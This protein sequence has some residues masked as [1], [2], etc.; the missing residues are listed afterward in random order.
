MRQDGTLPSYEQLFGSLDFRE[1]DEARSVYSPAAYLADLLQLLDDSFD[2]VPLTGEDRRPDLRTVP[3]DVENT[4]TEVPYLDI[5]NQVLARLIGKDALEELAELRFPFT[6]PFSLAHEQVKRYLFHARVSPVELYTQ[7]AQRIDA[8]VVAREYLG[9]TTGDVELLTTTTA[10]DQLKA[11]YGLAAEAS[12]TE[13]ESVD[14]F[15]LTTGLTRAQ[16]HELLYQNLGPAESAAG[17]FVHQGGPCVTL[18]AAE[19]RLTPDDGSASVPAEWFERVHRFL[20]LVRRTGLS[21]ADTDLV[22]RSCCGN[23]LDA[24]ALRTI[25]VV[26]DLH[27]GQNLPVDVVC[28]LVSP[29]STSGAGADGPPQDLFN[30]VF[31]APF[32]ATER[33]V[34]S[35]SADLPPSYADLRRLAATGDLL[36][37]QNREYR[38]RVA[39]AVGLTDAGIA[40]VVSRMRARFSGTTAQSSLFDRGASELD[41]LSLLH[42]VGR[43]AGALD[44][45][46]G[47]LF[48]LLDVLEADSS[49]R[50][51]RTF[52]E[53]LNGTPA[54]VDL[55]R[56]LETPDAGPALR[57]MQILFGVVRW[58]R[59]AG[60]GSD[61]LVGIVGGAAEQVAADGDVLGAVLAEL[62]RQFET[63][64]LAPGTFVSDRFGERASRVVRDALAATGSV[65]SRRDPRLLVPE[66]ARDA[67][68]A[69]SEAYHAMAN[70]VVITEDDFCGLGLGARLGAKI[71]ANLVF[72]GHVQPSGALVEASLP[73]TAAG[74][75]ISTD[76]ERLRERLFELIS[77]FCAVPGA[78]FYPSDLADFGDLTAAQQAEL[79]DNLVYN[80]YLDPGGVVLQPDFF[81]ADNAAA[82]ALNADLGDA[83]PAVW[84]LLRDRIDRFRGDPLTLD[85]TI[86]ADLPLVE[87]QRADLLESLRFNGYID[88]ENRYVDKPALARL[89]LDDL[90][91]AVQFYPYRRAVLDAM[92]AQLEAARNELLTLTAEQFG[93][94]AD[95]VVARRVVGRLDGTYLVDGVLPDEMRLFFADPGSQLDADDLD[96]SFSA[97]DRVTITSQIA[98]ILAEEQPYRLDFR[99]LEDLGFDVDESTRLAGVLVDAGHLNADLSVPE[100]RLTFFGNVNNALGFTL[101]GLVDYSKDIFFLLHAIAR[102]TSAG[103]KEITTVLADLAGRQLAVLFGV[104]QDA[105]GLPAATVEAICRGVAA[106]TGRAL[107]I[108][109]APALAGGGRSAA[110]PEVR[111]TYRRIRRFAWLAGKLGLDAVQVVAAFQDQDLVAKFA[112][113]LSLPPGVDRIDALLDSADGNVYLF[114]G[115]GYWVYSPAT[116]ALVTPQARP[117]NELSPRLS[118]LVAVDA[119]F[120]D[121]GGT[122]WIVGRTSTAPGGAG[123]EVFVRERGTHHWTRREQPWGRI[124]NNFDDPARIDS[125]FVDDTGR[126]YLFCGDQYVRYSG[127][128]YSQVDEG[129]PRLIGDWRE[130]EGDGAALPVGFRTVDASFQDRDGVTH[131]FGGGRHLTVGTGAADQPVAGAWGKV[132]NAFAGAGRVD[133]AYAEPARAVL[134]AGDQV[135]RYSDCIENDDVYVDE[136]DPCGIGSYL[137]GVPAGF[138]GGLDAAFTDPAGVLHLFKNGRTVALREG[139]AGPVEPTAERWGALRPVLSGGTVDSAVVGLDGKTYLFSGDR[140][141][142]YSGTDYSVA[143]VGYPRAIAADWG[144]LLRVDASFVLDQATYLFGTAGKLFDLPPAHEV[145]LDASRMSRS[146]RLKFLEHGIA[147]AED[148]PV[149]GASPQ[150]HVTADNQMAFTLRREADRIEVHSDAGNPARW[151]VRYSSRDY[152]IPDA[153][154]PK[155]LADNWWNLPAGLLEGTVDAVFT[156]RDNRTYLFSGDSYVVFDNKRRWWSES[157]SLRQLWGSLP[158]DRVDAAFV[159]KDGRTYVFSGDRYVR[160]AGADY[161]RVDDRYPAPV[162]SYWGTVTNN[163]ART[164]RVDAALVL[165]QNTYL[166]SGNQ[167]VRYTGTEYATVDD[168]YP[169]NLDSLKSEPRLANLHV[170]LSGGLDAAFADRHTVYLFTGGRWHA[171]SDVDY[172]SYP[173]LG[174]GPGGCAFVEDGSVLVEEPG[175][176]LRYSALEGAEV[177]RTPVRPRTLRAVPEGFRRG[178]DAVLSGVDGNT[179]L[180]KQDSCFNVEANGAYPLAE[181]WGRPRNNLYHDGTVDAGFV[182]RD[183][184]TYVFSGDQFIVYGAGSG[185]DGEI[186]GEP[187]PVAEH[188]GGLSSVALAYMRDGRTYLF[189][190]PDATG[191]TRYVVYSGDDY[192]EP[193]PGGSSSADP[194]FWDIPQEYRPDG[195]VAPDAVVFEGG[196]MLVVT[197]D[198]VVRRHEPTGTWSPPQPLSRFWPG[199]DRERT[200]PLTAGFRG[201]D[202]A[203]YLFFADQFTRCDGQTCSPRRPVRDAWGR[204]RNNFVAAGGRGRVDAA[205][206]DRGRTTFLFSGDQYVRYSR[207]DYRYADAGYP[208]PIAGNLRTEEAFASLP[209]S[210]EDVVAARVEAAGAGGAVIDAVIGNRRTVYLFV[211]GDC[212][213]VSRAPAAT[214]DLGIL[215]QVRNTIAQRGRVDA[216]LVTGGHTYLFSGDQYVRYTGGYEFVDE[217]YPRSIDTGLPADLGVGAL[218][219]EFGDGVDVAFRG[220]DGHTYLFAGPQYLQLDGPATAGPQPIGDAW[221]RI[222][223]EFTA[224]A[225]VDAAFVAPTGE[226]YAFRRGQYVRYRPGEFDRVEE[227]FPR[228]VKDDW[229]ELPAD[230]EDGIDG[231]FVFEGR[232][233]LCRDG[234][235]VR[236]SG[237]DYHRVD[238]RFPQMVAQRWSDGP[239]YQL[240]DVYTIARVAALVRAHDGLAAFLSA[241]PATVG[242]PYLRL[243][244]LFGW[245]AEEVRWARRHVGLLTGA[246][247]PDE[248]VEL[249]FLLRLADVFAIA[250]R[251]G[252]GP[253]TVYTR[254]WL[255]MYGDSASPPA[256]ALRDLLARKVG[257]ADWAVL[258]RQIHDEVNLLERDALLSVVIARTGLQSSRDLFDRLLIDVDMGSRATT[259]PIREAVAATQLYL[260][261]YF[262]NLEEL[263]AAPERAEEVRNR[264][265]TWWQWMR[266]YRTWEANRKVFLYPENYLRPELR[267]SKTPAFHTLESDLLQ[268]EI[269]PE[270]V[271]RA[272]KKYLD[273]Y[274]EVS[275]LAIGG[276]YVYIGDDDS[277]R[278]LVLFGR[279]RTQPR[280]YYY[281]RARFRSGDKLSASWEPWRKV[282]VQIDA[283]EVN[284]VHAFDRVFVFWTTVE[285]VPPAGVTSTTLVARRDGDTNEVSA[286]ATT[287]RVKIYY[288][289]QNLNGEWVPAQTLPMDTRQDGTIFGVT[290]SVTASGD[291]GDAESIVV[292]CSY[293]V[294][295]GTGD[296]AHVTRVTQASALTPELYAVG[297][298]AG[299][300]PELAGP[301]AKRVPTAAAAVV[302]TGSIFDIFEG[303]DEISAV[304]AA[305]VANTP[306]IV[307]FNSPANASY[308]P[309]F[310]VDHKGGS[311]LCYPTAVAPGDEPAPVPLAGNDAGLPAWPRIDAA[312]ETA[313]GTRYF[314]DNSGRRYVTATG[315][316]LGP[317][318][319]IADSWG[320]TPNNITRTG[321][322]DAILG[323]GRYTYVF[324]GDQYFRYSGTLFGPV[325]AGYPK[326]LA[327]N[328][329]RLPKWPRVDLAFTDLAGTEWFYS[330]AQGLLVRGGALD[331]PLRPSDLWDRQSTAADKPPRID[332]DKID[333]VLI[334]ADRDHTYVFSGSQYRRFSGRQYREVDAGYPTDIEGNGEGIPALPRIDAAFRS[335]RVT[336][337]FTNASHAYVEIRGTTADADYETVTRMTSQIGR[338]PGWTA[339]DAAYVDGGYLYVTSGPQ[340]ARYTLA[341]GAPIPDTVDEGYPKQM[342]RALDAVFRRGTRRY[343]FS[344]GLYSQLQPG[345][346][347]D[348]VTEF[349]PIERNWADLPADFPGQFTGVLDSDADGYLYLFFTYREGSR[350]VSR[351]VR[352]P[353]G[354]TVSRPYELATLPLEIV[355]LTTSTAAQLNQRLLAGGVPALLDL[356]TQEIDESPA[357]TVDRSDRNTIQLRGDRVTAARLPASSHLDFQSANGIYYW[358]IFFHAPALIA[359]ALNDAQRFEDARTWYEYVFNPTKPDGYW[360]F[361]PFLAADVAALAENSAREIAELADEVQ[362]AG[363]A[364]ATAGLSDTLAPI[365]AGLATLAPAF[366]QNRRLTPD[367]EAILDMF[368][369]STLPTVLVGVADTIAARLTPRVREPRRTALRRALAAARELQERTAVVAGLRRQYDYLG[370]RESLLEAYRNDPFDPHA[371]ADLRPVAHRRAVVMAYIDNLLDWGD[372]LFRQYT[373]ESV[374][375]ARMLYILAWDL[376]GKRPAGIGRRALP[377][378]RTFQQLEDQPDELDPLPELTAGGALL[379][380]SGAVYAGLANGYFHVPDN[381]AFREYW[382]RVEDRLYKIRQSLNIMGIS[383]PLPLFEPEQDVMALV[384]ATAAGAPSL[385]AA[386]AAAALVPHFRFDTT[387]AAARDLVDRLCQFGN[388]LLG[389]LDRR[390]SE[391]LSLLQSRQ[392]GVILAM[393]RAITEAQ[394]EIAA[395][396][397]RELEAGRDAVT[398]RVQYY[399]RLST[400]GLSPLEQAQVD[401]MITAATLHMASGTMKIGSAIA[402][403]APQTKLG[404][405][406]I[407]VEWGGQELG[408]VLDKGS[409]I[410]QTL[411]EGFSILGELLGVRAEQARSQA[412]W[413]F[414]LS[415]ARGDLAQLEQRFA[416]AEQALAVAQRE[417]DVLRQQ[418]ANQQEVAAFLTGKFTGAGLYQWMAGRL[419][420]LYFQAYQLAYDLARQAELAFQFERGRGG[421]EAT[422]I[423][424]QYW[425]SLRGGLLA[426]ESLSLDLEL[427]GKACRDASGRGL[428]ITKRISLLELDPVALYRLTSTGVCEFS[429]TEATFDH[430]FPGH[431]RRQ[432]RTVAVSFDGGDG[433]PVR[434]N[435]TLT[436]LGHK[437]V[438]EA[439]PKAVKHLLDPTQPPP[440]TVRSDWRPSQQIVLS[441]GDQEDTGLFELR[442][443]DPRYLPF[444]GTGAISTWRLALTGLRPPGLRDVTLII[445][446]T[447]QPGDEV[448]A[449]AVKGMLKPYQAARFVDVAREFPEQWQDFLDADQPELTLPLTLN[450][451]PGMTGHQITGI[452]SRYENSNGGSVRFVLGGPPALTLTEGALLPTPG[453]TIGNGSNWVLTLDGDRTG[454]T[455]VGL[456]LTYQ[457]SDQ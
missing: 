235:Y 228:L 429:L 286:P 422:Y 197:G 165:D 250:D 243:T 322:V 27:R 381:S 325:D 428:E 236:Y 314:F 51:Q 52:G 410:P 402:Y 272:Y 278:D 330:A 450:M 449:N 432:I 180:F 92:Q 57:L 427:L 80:G 347:L 377:A 131:L 280:R 380:G 42:R 426:G 320:R 90:G 387:F 355:R 137:P 297:L 174:P 275:R 113:P 398:A 119:A 178:L 442:L 264:L 216:A 455:N 299:T 196:N 56:V 68:R 183:G 210:F 88:E 114:H 232:T 259:S 406:I 439:D 62:G 124:R 63:V 411:A 239:D 453:L 249:E 417:A 409:E 49:L 337:F 457:A 357:F 456:V 59:A 142:R 53:P 48:D 127:S 150:W 321:T 268:G 279:T 112:E 171:V 312:F 353:T 163:I 291:D 324:C 375:E 151:Y 273:E 184:K 336:Y 102:E 7:F 94:I 298:P 158:F 220:T 344:G 14:R 260:H 155:P 166:F 356:S 295:T 309:W 271:E 334:D 382:A 147:V 12:F 168:G 121:S 301:D 3:L 84:A 370:D 126:T 371:I 283:D 413:A 404:P 185:P 251:L 18:D 415:T 234:K 443:D 241:G 358:E 61:D 346:E 385:P 186:E 350:Y 46:V 412:E 318:I 401:L 294:T 436:Q 159:G 182:G 120:I 345:K 418:I 195:F 389:V 362:A 361:L 202:G 433:E 247:A 289:F 66:A 368:A 267:A 366:R 383:Q 284:P 266:S 454:L 208:K 85:P 125:A 262:L 215:G 148:R 79:Y 149:T 40:A 109:V 253:S 10:S 89:P 98:R 110:G 237:D 338:A 274:T 69:A 71:F 430:E 441:G 164:G 41:V 373:P 136:G 15:L 111:R 2:E 128:D 117:L 31:N 81:A 172:R 282:D 379:E 246:A 372:L 304:A 394:V 134:I 44:V 205:F 332:A 384:R 141:L 303:D 65:V 192:A 107:E 292:S 354:A 38:V 378:T 359:R 139:A 261:R 122:E 431:F 444:E 437:T 156:G 179:Y 317:E 307:R 342:R 20:R 153:G 420:S 30:R 213:V 60:I 230:F 99:A 130:G 161:T 29:I 421:S 306:R 348:A 414:Q 17:F 270:A 8:D 33:T 238:R 293:S 96:G 369:S 176:W 218:P 190:K 140:Y 37:A 352:Y 76:F 447:A 39:A 340:Y 393:T 91:L 198:Q 227:G 435:A 248:R 226:L 360:R 451:F 219:D 233:Y 423:R 45:S 19:G 448:F 177:T 23:R 257:P 288:S 316:N 43:L 203:T 24:A 311:F 313:D 244:E 118:G 242:D 315:G 5:V 188:W 173:R 434:L 392:E 231:A 77:G 70:L 229:G 329:D 135:V 67:T 97:A 326:P 187:R 95:A 152:A 104:L 405:F 87:Q 407:G 75:R 189:E 333:A 28:G 144:G 64:S 452:Y 132:R 55:Y 200:G 265:R 396:S 11:R 425:E 106:G 287:E 9:L 157:R 21:I 22:L 123:S 252:T 160:Y 32:V 416:G 276:G 145:D 36:A 101:D 440:D 78:S 175:G 13:L 191:A 115:A 327:A 105:L 323:R 400:G 408:A 308:G 351:Y 397:L 133:A 129:Y 319:P 138:D 258:Q 209:E 367:E 167:Y 222:H 162:A 374:D 310:S 223:N 341:A 263:P 438:L 376:L 296:Q 331:V 328:S 34:I 47:E 74:L 395:A 225:A 146:V 399:E 217:G 254:V 363:V 193:D 403:A 349:A 25:A 245:D 386:P 388:Q 108:L 424:P 86:F 419:S 343:V 206:V 214:Y 170:D 364:D 335:G 391:E 302:G 50:G 204:S 305:D 445:R 194:G 390:D 240:Q 207:A 201:A 199:I 255:P 1:A 72:T 6:M 73:A 277:A 269:T 290:L 93:D 26:L 281:R 446:Y 154:Y 116:Q 221:G 169:R 256:Q 58:M 365:L 4:S 212:H 35:V 339:V 100:D 211:G 285:A 143:D 224:G 16:L 300:A 54:P 103:I 83:A 181:D 82:F